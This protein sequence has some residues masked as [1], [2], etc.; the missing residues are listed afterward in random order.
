MM[1]EHDVL[2]DEEDASEGIVELR[3]YSAPLPIPKPFL[4]WHRPRK[5]FVRDKQW[6]QQISRLLHDHPPLDNVLRY[7]GLPGVDLLDLRYFNSVVCQP[8][9]MSL[10][11]LG[12][13]NAA[14]PSTSAGIELNISTDELMK[15]AG[16]D[17]RSS[18]IIDD[19]SSL[20]NQNSLASKS[21][22]D[23]GPYDVINLDLCDGFGA[24]P[25]ERGGSSYYSAVNSLLALQSRSKRPW[26]FLLTTRADKPNIDPEVL[27]K[28]IDKYLKNLL[29][30]P[31]MK[32]PRAYNAW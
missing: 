5:Q 19:F 28:M 21:A 11:F 8:K 25:P 13:N 15:S 9:A 30:K 2:N 16:V 10:C 14:R 7:L 32:V 27:S 1:N 12:F 3:D 31:S 6:S 18:I 22:R 24:K 4:P 23:V 17:P 26:L 20:A 29:Y